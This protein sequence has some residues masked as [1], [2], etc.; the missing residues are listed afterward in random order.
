[1]RTLVVSN[2]PMDA[3][4]SRLRNA[5]RAKLD[6]QGPA[7]SDFLEMERR[8]SQSQPEMVIVVLS[9]DVP[10][11]L[12]VV[13]RARRQTANPILAVGPVSEPKL[14]LRALQEG[15]DHYLDEAD[16]EIGLDAVLS[17]MQTKE[18]TKTPTGR[19]IAVLSASGGSG[20]STI[21][22]NIATVLAKENK[23]CTLIDLK[24]GR[25]DLAALLD[26]K[27]VYHLADLCINVD[28]LD[29]AMFD[30]MLIAHQSGVRLLASPQVFGDTR[31][32]SAQGV[33]Q[34]LA[35]AR[36]LGANVVVDLED[37]F[38][39]EQILALRQASSILVVSRLDFTS[40]RNARRIL[41][42]LS[43]ELEIQRGKVRLV[44]NRLGQPGELP[45]T[46][47]E[48]ALGGRIAHYVPDDPRT[49]NEAN[50]IGVPAVLRSP[51]ARV[52]KRL[53]DL[54]RSVLERRRPDKNGNHVAPV[55][56]KWLLGMFSR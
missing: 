47:A 14:I 37:C 1:M 17:R 12:D 22:V 15:A 2:N 39:E 45:L 50:N 46:E 38:H 3:V 54:A 32:V 13:R 29:A 10:Q 23:R 42:H 35:Y 55:R 34:A 25:G 20:A 27:P 28:R 19:L 5:V 43:S 53:T 33:S 48:E 24:P 26:L 52:S 21:A 8:F 4:S 7:I 31:M 30:K 56:S 36:K 44:I 40:M 49:I 6:P 16:A 9:P 11:G 41:E 18:E 51:K